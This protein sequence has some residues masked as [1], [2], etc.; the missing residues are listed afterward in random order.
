MNIERLRV[1]QI[2]P[3]HSFFYVRKYWFY[4][5]NGL[6][7]YFFASLPMLNVIIWSAWISEE[8]EFISL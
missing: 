3:K 4:F 7:M 1:K 8:N 5:Y 2:K 6:H